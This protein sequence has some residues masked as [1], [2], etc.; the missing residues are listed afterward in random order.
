MF[1]KYSIFRDYR[2]VKKI[3]NRIGYSLDICNQKKIYMY[4]LHM[5]RIIIKILFILFLSFLSIVF[6]GYIGYHILQFICIIMF[7]VS[8]SI[9]FFYLTKFRI[10]LRKIYCSSCDKRMQIKTILVT[11]GEEGMCLVCEDC[12]K[13]AYSFYTR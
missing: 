4:A 2:H 8:L 12:R 3:Y 10:K 5:Y 6:F 13:Y 1:N 11:E 7:F 9:S